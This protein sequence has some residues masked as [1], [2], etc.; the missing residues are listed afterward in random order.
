MGARTTTVPDDNV[1]VAAASRDAVA[2]N[3]TNATNDRS[4][5]SVRSAC[6]GGDVVVV[7]QA[8]NIVLYLRIYLHKY[9]QISADICAD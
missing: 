4:S 9:L 5:G 1:T 2:T 6:G 8:D 3:A 7:H